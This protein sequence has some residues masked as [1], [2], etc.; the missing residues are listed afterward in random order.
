MTTKT[1][2]LA[3]VNAIET[4]RSSERVLN[5]IDIT[6]SGG[7]GTLDTHTLQTMT[8]SAASLRQGFKRVLTAEIETL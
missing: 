6:H 2:V 8:N 4:L 1:R 5:H 7:I 3:L